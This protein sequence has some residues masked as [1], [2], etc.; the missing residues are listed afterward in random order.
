MVA[1]TLVTA[2][3]LLDFPSE[4]RTEL[5]DGV[6]IEVS[7]TSVG[8]A[9]VVQRLN[10]ALVAYMLQHPIGELW[11]DGQ[12]GFSIGRNPDSVLSPDLAITERPADVD[13]RTPE[14]GCQ[15]FPSSSLRSC[16]RTIVSG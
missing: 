15:P 16:R 10:F 7:P 1:T 14:G 3:E 4:P 2:G 8:H 12:L 6:V 13:R 11:T 9:I 5:I